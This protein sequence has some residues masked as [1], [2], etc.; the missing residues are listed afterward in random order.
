ML[1]D[2]DLAEAIVDRILERGRLIVMDGP[3]LRTLHIDQDQ[4]PA[5][6]RISGKGRPQYPEPTGGGLDLQSPASGFGW[7]DVGWWGPRGIEQTA[8]MCPRHELVGVVETGRGV[9]Q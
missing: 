9:Y 5:P 3:S 7:R 2:P 6:A 4:L 8:A 1:H